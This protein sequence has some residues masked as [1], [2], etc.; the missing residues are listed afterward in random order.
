M[1]LLPLALVV[2][3]VVLLG[4]PMMFDVFI[5]RHFIH[6][7]N[8]SGPFTLGGW[9]LIILGGIGYMIDKRNHI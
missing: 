2:S 1:F 6:N 4:V 9:I 7:P 3:I 5:L 8:I